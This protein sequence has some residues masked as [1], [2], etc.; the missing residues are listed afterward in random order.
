[1]KRILV[2]LAAL[3][4]GPV[5]IVCGIGEYKDSK[6]LQAQGKTIT[7]KVTKAEETVSRKGRHKYWL[8]IEFQPEQ[9]SAQTATSQ[10]S[11]DRF[12][13]AV[14]DKAIS[15]VYLPS[16]PRVFQFGEKAETRYG[17][18]VFGSVLLVGAL[19]F[20]G[21]VRFVRRAPAAGTNASAQ[22]SMGIP[23]SPAPAAGDQ[24]KVDD[25]QKA[26]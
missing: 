25:Q 4:G 14:A 10:I 11:S 15:L 24:Q 6:Q 9:G 7:A 26:A 8:T 22:G 13:R 12:S 17:S 3:I 21:Y 18:V 23:A 16:N 2:F 19:A 1:M 20:L 5:L